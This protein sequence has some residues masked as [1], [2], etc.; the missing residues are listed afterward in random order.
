MTT[1][2]M[3]EVEDGDDGPSA[4]TG[5]RP[6]ALDED[7]TAQVR[8]A[9]GKIQ[10]TQSKDP[11]N[12]ETNLGGPIVA[13]RQGRKR[14]VGPLLYWDVALEYDP[15][16]KRLTLTKR[17]SVPDLNTMLLEP[18]LQPEQDMGDV[19]AAVRAILVEEEMS[20]SSLDQGCF[21]VHLRRMMGWPGVRSISPRQSRSRSDSWLTRRRTAKNFAVQCQGDPPQHTPLECSDPQRPSPPRAT[22]R[23]S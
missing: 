4:E 2:R 21:E 11:Y 10:R 9:A 22:H 16:A 8:A 3:R 19:L 20:R 23:G 15:G 7:V 17:S 6:S 18:F 14:V 5:E 12:R 1:L 13:L